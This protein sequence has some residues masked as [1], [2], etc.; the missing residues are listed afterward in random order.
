MSKWALLF[1]CIVCI[2]WVF[3]IFDKHMQ[4]VIHIYDGLWISYKNLEVYY[5]QNK[6]FKDPN[7]VQ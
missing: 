6:R 3:V 7:Q 5:F 4:N 2:I 1:E